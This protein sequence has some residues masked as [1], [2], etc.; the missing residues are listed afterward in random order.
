MD[1]TLEAA[2]RKDGPIYTYGPLIHNPQVLELLGE[3]GVMALDE[4]DWGKDLREIKGK[5]SVTSSSGPMASRRKNGS[6]SRT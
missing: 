2:M 3:K 6:G 4:E 5:D 1:M